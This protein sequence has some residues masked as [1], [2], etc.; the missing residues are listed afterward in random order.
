[1]QFFKKKYL[2]LNKMV[3]LCVAKT[4]SDKEEEVDYSNNY[5]F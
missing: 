4:A 5:T 2:C 3:Q 1:M